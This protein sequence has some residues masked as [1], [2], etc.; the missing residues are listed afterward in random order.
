MI[1]VIHAHP[2]P[3]HSR[4]CKELLAAVR[5][6]P[7]VEVRS[8][9]DLY[10]DFDIDIATEQQ[11]LARAQLVVWLHPIYWYSAPGLL[12]H[13]FDK[14]LALGWAYGRGGT[15]LHGKHCLWVASIGG[16]EHTY[17]EDHSN[18]LPFGAY[19]A[20]IEQTA[21]YC[22]MHWEKPEL[23]FDTHEISHDKLQ[24]RAGQLRERLAAWRA[25]QAARKAGN[26]A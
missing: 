7:D 10:P 24:A 20:P 26:K 5:D 23:V 6:L 2:Y 13:W 25:Q 22:G 18:L 16:A 8:L 9:Y 17:A 3:A 14:V 12:K 11:A 21:R 19:M 4:V 1:L 15:A